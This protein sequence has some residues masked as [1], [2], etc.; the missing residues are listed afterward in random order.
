LM[1][2]D[3]VLSKAYTLPRESFSSQYIENMSNI[4]EDIS[5]LSTII[6]F[7]NNKTS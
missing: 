1:L 7:L 2:H 5:I 6:T 3:H 4:V